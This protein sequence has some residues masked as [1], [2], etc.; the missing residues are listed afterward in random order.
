MRLDRGV[1]LVP[2]KK[3]RLSPQKLPL[4]D[5]KGTTFPS[6]T[7]CLRAL[8]PEDLDLLYTIENDETMW[9]V[10]DNPLPYSRYALRQYL[11]EQPRDI[12][13]AR[14]LRLAVVEKATGEAVGLVDLVNYSPADRRAE[15]CIAVLREKRGRGI[16]L[17]ALGV[18]EQYAGHYL[19]IRMLYAL[20]SCTNNPLCHKLFLRAGYTPAAVL[21][22]WHRHNNT[23]E[24]VQV[25]IREIDKS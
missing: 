19:G 11:A 23:Y 8:E 3:Y 18:L 14:E 6:E 1:L 24:D 4:S 7:V 20:V 10:S 9:D 25:F 21:P 2:G 12:H 15:V 22:R 16:G 17:A 5:M 13:E